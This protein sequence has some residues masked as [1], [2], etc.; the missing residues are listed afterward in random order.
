MVPEGGRLHEYL[1]RHQYAPVLCLWS[2]F[3][4][5]LWAP[6]RQPSHH[7]QCLF[8]CTSLGHVQLVSL[9]GGMKWM[10]LGVLLVLWTAVDLAPA[11]HKGMIIE[12]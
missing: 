9:L 12:S 1:G 4:P 6:W 7:T 3:V 10:P 8:L 5:D 11:E 2:S